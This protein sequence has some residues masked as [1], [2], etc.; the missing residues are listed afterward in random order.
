LSQ[1]PV[2]HAIEQTVAAERLEGWAPT[3]EHRADLIRLANDEIVFSDYLTEYRQRHPPPD[4]PSREL[5]RIFRRARPYL[6]PGTTLL[7]NNF[8]AQSAA[9][10]ADLEYI[11]TAGRILQW[12]RLLVDGPVGSEHLDVR[13]IHQH[14]FADVYAWAGELR[15]VELRRGDDAF[16]WHSGLAEATAKVEEQAH[17]VAA[18]EPDLAALGYELSRLYANYNHVHPF[19]EGNGR[20]GTLLL[21]TV[22]ALCGCR[23]D[24]SV[25]SRVEWYAASRDSMPFRRSASVGQANHR[26]FLSL[27][28]RAL[29]TAGE[30]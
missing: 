5:G 24:L 19:R 25:I 6:I 18:A 29:S 28:A 1:S 20:T 27:M 14:V 12:H 16:A 4:E 3:D 11:A 22:A 10:L 9:M 8:G 23:L 17:T 21:H 7:R 30:G 15:T 26:P 13:R 2:L